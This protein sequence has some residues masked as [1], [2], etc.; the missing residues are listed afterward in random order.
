MVKLAYPLLNSDLAWAFDEVSMDIQTRG[1]RDIRPVVVTA[2]VGAFQD[3]SA[4][5]WPNI[6]RSMSDI[7]TQLAAIVVSAGNDAQK[8][9]RIADV[10]KMPAIWADV[11]KDSPLI[12]VGAVSD[13]GTPSPTS[14]GLTPVTVWA[15]GI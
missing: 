1:H 11:D 9:G 15:P 2:A 4:Y 13:A 3:P 5:P 10:D 7:F 8:P 12:V 6:K 14:Q